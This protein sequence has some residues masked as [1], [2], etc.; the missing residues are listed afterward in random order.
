ME[1]PPVPVRV[2]LTSPSGETWELGE[3]SEDNVVRGTAADFC[4]V[5]TRRRHLLDTGL[6]V[7]GAAAREWLE[8]AQAFAGPPGEGRRPG[9]FPP[10]PAP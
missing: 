5:A 8:I 3:P 4:R 7:T 1:L 9:Q 2:S 10:E 6:E